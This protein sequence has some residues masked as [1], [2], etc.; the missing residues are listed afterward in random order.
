MHK[1]LAVFDNASKKWTI[2]GE[3]EDTALKILGVVASK[4]HGARAIQLP[5]RTHK[6][7]VG[8]INAE[9]LMN[10]FSAPVLSSDGKKVKLTPNG[11]AKLAFTAVSP[12]KYKP[13]GI[14]SKVAGKS[15][16]RH[17]EYVLHSSKK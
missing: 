17:M 15:Q 5:N 8:I 3:A 12:Q 1:A 13:R 16:Y 10:L 14:E 7:V 11:D 6:I 4:K 2:S 9:T